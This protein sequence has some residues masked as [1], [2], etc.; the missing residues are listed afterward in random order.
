MQ[1]DIYE[2]FNKF[3]FRCPVLPYSDTSS[4][5]LKGDAGKLAGTDFMDAIYV[6]SSEVFDAINA[7][8]DQQKN[9]QKIYNTL[10]KYYLRSLYRSTP[11][12]LMA[13]V[14]IGNI[15]DGESMIEID[16]QK[17]FIRHSRLDMDY[18]YRVAVDLSRL[19]FIKKY[20]HYTPNT[21]IYEVHEKIRYVE[22]TVRDNQRIHV[23]NSADNSFYVNQIIQSAKS[24]LPAKELIATIEDSG[25]EEGEKLAFIEQ[26]IDAQLLVSELDFSVTGAPMELQLL[27]SL[28]NILERT[29]SIEDRNKVFAIISQIESILLLLKQ[30]DQNG[31]NNDNIHLYAEIE[32][33]VKQIGSLYKRKHLIQTDSQIKALHAELN[34]DISDDVLKAVD[35]VS[36]FTVMKPTT[37][38]ADFKKK[39]YERWEEREIPLVIALDN[40][41]GIGYPVATDQKM[42]YSPVLDDLIFPPDVSMNKTINVNQKLSD[43]WVGKFGEALKNKANEIIVT[44]EDIKEFPSRLGELPCT[45]S[46]MISLLRVK[47]AEYST[48]DNCFLFK[49]AGGSS[50]SNL[51]SRFCHNDSDV[52]SLSKSITNKEKSFYHESIVAEIVHLPESRTGNILMRPHTYEHE[53]P[54]L[55]KSGLP[56]EFQIPVDDLMISMRANNLTITSKKLKKAIIPRLTSAHNFQHNSL[57]IYH[58]LCDLQTD[59][60]LPWVKL[61]T[62]NIEDSNKYIPRISY[63]K[64][65]ILQ[66]AQWKLAKKDYKDLIDSNNG[67][68]LEKF[69][70][71]KQAWLI[72]D[73]I[74]LQEGDN[75]LVIN[76]ND[77]DSI[78]LFVSEIKN[79][80]AITIVEFLFNLH[81]KQLIFDG[82]KNYV[83]E[84]IFFYSKKELNYRVPD[85]KPF[86]KKQ[87][88][89]KAK[90]TFY[91][92][93]EWIY[94]KIY[95]GCK[96]A[97]E[98]L[99]NVLIHSVD[100]FFENKMISKWFFVRYI[101]NDF[102]LRVRFL[103]TD[104]KYLNP[105]ILDL[106]KKLETFAISGI[107]WKIQLDTYSR[108]LERY[109]PQN[110]IDSESIFSIDSDAVLKI[111]SKIEGDYSQI[112]RWF[113]GI[114][115]IEGYL[116]A[117]ELSMED[118]YAFVTNIRDSLNAEFKADKYLK[119]QLDKKYRN[120][121]LDIEQWAGLNSG[122]IPIA[123]ENYT[124][125]IEVIFD[126]DAK[127]AEILKANFL[128]DSQKIITQNL[129]SY[130]HMSINRLFRSQNR[131]HEFVLYWILEKYYRSKIG[132]M[133]WKAGIN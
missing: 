72:P 117:F 5:L 79:K 38:L 1:Q 87:S 71:F 22:Y 7:D 44:G 73:F 122:S 48:S 49:N 64:N 101:E 2:A 46:A 90:R 36:R 118:K 116:S 77:T 104:L 83:N 43:F 21:S 93:D 115:T 52:A 92:G 131:L 61:D 132:K 120:Y 111:L 110:I 107:I 29:T 17:S 40:E 41:I 96:S 25:F 42:D 105:I 27:N 128:N 33:I 55:S 11:F 62:G 60:I 112:E 109:G 56:D 13:G 102:H 45:F 108:E 82:N 75:E 81:S 58:F 127:I 88:L 123:M 14:G 30:I 124:S 68:T 114:R 6:A 10:L 59:N 47:N 65:I 26:L 76:T 98:L 86:I 119:K 130:I 32:V 100:L 106:N 85:I 133:E 24:G 57:P 78:S 37:A 97:D 12:G 51:I 103:A 80:E 3:I 19:D 121:K 129:A 50:G 113:C 99:V 4:A 89:Q 74:A 16:P 18:L 34:K 9:Y 8:T 70:N 39:F 54:F 125:L 23:L 20:L 63:Q 84:L 94:F 95:T 69:T 28:N 31:T 67:S 66:P 15:N 126:R 53:I 91:P 35:I